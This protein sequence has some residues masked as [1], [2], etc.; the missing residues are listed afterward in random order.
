MH[1]SIYYSNEIK[2]AFSN[3]GNYWLKIQYLQ[4]KID[5]SFI[6]TRDTM[7]ASKII[8]ELWSNKKKFVK[9]FSFSSASSCI[10]SGSES[11]SNE[12]LE[13]E[14]QMEK[15]KSISLTLIELNLEQDTSDDRDQ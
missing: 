12:E 2:I 9:T 10:T 7:E 11:L 15:S 14:I 6:H 13:L 5:R 8:D 4:Y 1:L 3:A